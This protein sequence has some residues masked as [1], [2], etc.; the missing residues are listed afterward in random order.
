M[1]AEFAPSN[2]RK[3]TKTD[4]ADSKEIL[5][6]GSVMSEFPNL[7]IQRVLETDKPDGNRRNTT[8]NKEALSDPNLVSEKAYFVDFLIKSFFGCRNG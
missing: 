8:N 2:Q 6:S 3:M 7:N 4:R 1:V 5:R